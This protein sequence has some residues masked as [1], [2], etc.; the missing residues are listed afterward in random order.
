MHHRCPLDKVVLR[1]V[2]VLVHSFVLLLF[3]LIHALLFGGVVETSCI[4]KATCSSAP[5]VQLKTL[6]Q[7]GTSLG[8][9]SLPPYLRT[10]LS[11]SAFCPFYPSI[12][13]QPA[14][15]RCQHCTVSYPA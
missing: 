1:L 8:S 2:S 4:S 14:T 10:S 7:A 3:G 9:R 5:V 12:L 11:C 13:L 15:L 6:H